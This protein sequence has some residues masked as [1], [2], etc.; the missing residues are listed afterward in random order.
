LRIV[1]EFDAPVDCVTGT[2]MGAFVGGLY[3]AG[4]SAAEIND[5]M[6]CI[7]WELVFS[8]ATPRE[9]LTWRRKLD[10]REFLLPYRLGVREGGI[11]LPAGALPVQRLRLVLRELLLPV[12]GIRDFDRLPRQFRAVAADIVTGEKVVLGRQQLAVPFHR[13]DLLRTG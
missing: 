11:A 1:E 3:A 10:D 2:S 13:H 5:L 8:S 7:D 9:D 4:Y 12:Q 6:S